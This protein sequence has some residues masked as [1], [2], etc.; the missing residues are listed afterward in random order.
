[1]KI[2]QITGGLGIDGVSQHLRNV[3][4]ALVKQGHEV[5]IVLDPR[6]VSEVEHIADIAR[7]IY[8]RGLTV[9]PWFNNRQRPESLVLKLIK[10]ENPDIVITHMCTNDALVKTISQVRPTILFLHVNAISCIA[11]TRLLKWPNYKACTR[12]GGLQCIPNFYLRRCGSIRGLTPVQNYINWRHMRKALNRVA[13]VVVG[14]QSMKR[15]LLEEAG[16]E[17]ERIAVIPPLVGEYREELAE[18]GNSESMILYVGR[19]TPYKGLSYLIS[20]LPQ[21]KTPFKLVVAGD[22]YQ[23]GEVKKLC[24]KLRTEK[25]VEFL[26]WQRQANLHKLYCKCALVVLPSVWPEAF[27]MVGV[28]AMAHSRPVIAFDVGGISDWLYKGENGI[29]V[30]PMDVCGLANSIDSLLKSKSL[31]RR[32][33]KRGKE[34]FEEKFSSRRHLELLMAT[35]EEAK[36]VFGSRELASVDNQ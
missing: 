30:K 14:S 18:H 31:A 3:S 27:G 16:I 33:G 5:V 28:E 9:T 17:A 15:D 29:L 36:R 24:R 13:S 6:R 32:M 23:L 10:G 19:I 34:I 21:I 2:L 12:R 8:I 22:G 35:C 11:G 20:S 25:K 1:M 7:V 4:M 26:G